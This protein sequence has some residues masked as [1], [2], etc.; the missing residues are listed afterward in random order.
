MSRAENAHID[1]ALAESLVTLCRSL[2]SE[3]REV[4]ESTPPDVGG[5]LIGTE[6]GLRTAGAR[7]LALLMMYELMDFA[8]DPESWDIGFQAVEN[9]AHTPP[10]K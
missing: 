8:V 9:P 4:P 6:A 1:P 5:F 2:L 10:P 7:L 3:H